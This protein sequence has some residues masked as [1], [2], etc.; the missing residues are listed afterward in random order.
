MNLQKYGYYIMCVLLGFVAGPDLH[1]ILI[2]LAGVT[3]M[4]LVKER[5]YVKSGK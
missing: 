1:S 4:W 3:A 2:A 5:I